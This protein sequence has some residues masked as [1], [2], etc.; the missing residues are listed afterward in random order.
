MVPTDSD[1][2]VGPE[3]LRPLADDPAWGAAM[4]AVPRADFVP[5]TAWATPMD[6]SPGYWIDRAADPRRWAG[7]VYSDTTILTQ[8]ADGAVPLTPES[9]ATAAPSSSTTAPSLVAAFLGLLGA[10]PGDRVLE[11]GTGTGWTAALLSARL[12]A[13][14]VTSVEVDPRVAE[15]AAANLH[16]AGFAPVLRTGDGLLGDPAGAP[17][18]RVHVTCGIREVPYAWVRQ[19]RTGGVIALPWAPNH[20]A[21]HRLALTVEGDQAVG[22]LSGDAAFMMLRAQRFALPQPVGDRRDVA[23]RVDPGEIIGAGRGLAVALA[24]LLPGVVVDGLYPGSDRLGLRDPVSGSYATA[25]A[26]TESADSEAIEIGDRRLWR[27]LEDAYQTWRSLGRPA[28]DRFGVAV[29]PDGQHLWLDT[30]DNR[31]KEYA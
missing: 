17:Y 11:V 15:Q 6:H 10:A 23:A 25:V 27:E 16:R 4:A 3:A 29:S 22:R 19:T 5:E 8:V 21:G 24:G 28:A 1:P 7:A 13:A 31:I 30:P 20:I 2:V 12:G 26:A 14:N 9:A 18:D